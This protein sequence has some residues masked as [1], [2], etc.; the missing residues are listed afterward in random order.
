[1][2]NPKS[3]DANASKAAKAA[4][5]T[6]STAYN[7]GKVRVIYAVFPDAKMA[8]EVARSAVE[9]RLAACANVF[10]PHVS[11]YRW[12]DTVETS[13]EVAVLFKTSADKSSELIDFIRT[14]HSYETPAI[15]DFPVSNSNPDFANWIFD[16][17]R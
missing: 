16:S 14:N 11:V 8:G 9:K 3:F 7:L 12:K 6:E 13:E 15:L 1:M 17:C 4:D 10:T 5:S 2:T